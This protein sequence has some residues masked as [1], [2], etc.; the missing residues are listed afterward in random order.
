MGKGFQEVGGSLH[1]GAGDVIT[2]FGRNQRGGEA[3]II[4]KNVARTD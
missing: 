3:K 1:S 4:F 2:G